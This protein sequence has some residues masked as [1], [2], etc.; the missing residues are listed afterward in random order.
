MEKLVLKTREIREIERYCDFFFQ[1]SERLHSIVTGLKK[2]KARFVMRGDG[3]SYIIA[4][5][6]CLIRSCFV[7]IFSRTCVDTL[8]LSLCTQCCS[9]SQ[10][11]IN[12]AQA[13]TSAGPSGSGTVG[14]GPSGLGTTEVGPSGTAGTG[15]LGLGT[16]GAGPS[17]L[18]TVRAAAATQ[19]K[20]T[21]GVSPT[22][23]PGPS[24]VADSS[25]SEGSVSKPAASAEKDNSQTE[26]DLNDENSEIRRRRL[27]RFSSTVSQESADKDKED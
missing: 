13:S 11:L 21:A 27:E 17:G 3:Y 5:M 24:T 16:I 7:S 9:F 10:P 14:A 25:S 1:E 20:L 6:R 23:Q 19:T 2:I 12:Q 26:P 15:P 4:C 22:S 18:G 8:I